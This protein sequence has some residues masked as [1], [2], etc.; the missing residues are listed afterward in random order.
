MATPWPKEQ[1][2]WPTHHQ[3]HATELS[4]HLQTAARSI[5]TA[6][7]Q[8]LNPQPV[9]S[10]L[11][12]TL[13][14]LVKMQNL[15]ELGHLHRAIESLPAETKNANETTIRDTRTIEIAS[16]R[17]TVELR[18]RKL[19]K[20]ARWPSQF[21]KDWGNHIGNGARVRTPIYGVLAHGIRT[22]FNEHG[23]LHRNQRRPAA[24]QQSIHS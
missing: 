2:I 9:K 7:G 12:A 4:R 23:P 10:T 24:G 5:D 22:S 20:P 21:A 14:P 11:I 19:G 3:E 8:S 16:Q 17:N 6:N 15:L 18:P 13:S 1:I